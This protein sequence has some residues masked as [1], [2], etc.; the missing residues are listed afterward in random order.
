MNDPRFPELP[1]SHINIL[2][3][4]GK[5]ESY[6]EDTVIFELAELKYDF[7]VV[8]EGE[9]AVLDPNNDKKIIVVHGKSEFSGDSGMLSDRGAQFRAVAKAGSKLLRITPTKLKEAIAK[10]SNLSDLLLNAF[11]SV[12]ILF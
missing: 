1:Q 6:T 4:Y 8:L 3:E 7:F 11:Y 5:M 10:Y 2:K 12:K 9:I